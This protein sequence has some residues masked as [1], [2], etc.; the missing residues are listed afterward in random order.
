MS[1]KEFAYKPLKIEIER[2]TNVTESEYAPFFVFIN[3]KKLE[4]VKRFYIDLDCDK[5]MKQDKRNCTYANPW[6]YGVEYKD[7]P[8]E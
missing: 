5:I 4:G 2:N 1:N 8:D 6:V 7:Y 3:G